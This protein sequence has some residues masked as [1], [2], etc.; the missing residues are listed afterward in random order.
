MAF[1][2]LGVMGQWCHRLEDRRKASSS[3]QRRSWWRGGEY[4]DEKG[5]TLESAAGCIGSF[6][7]SRLR[8]VDSTVFVPI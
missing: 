2:E 1:V 7:H 4:M 3:M 8:G 6:E 5:E